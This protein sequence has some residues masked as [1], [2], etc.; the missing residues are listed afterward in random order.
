MLTGGGGRYAVVNREF[1]RVFNHE[2]CFRILLA[3]VG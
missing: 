1:F 2:G 3:I